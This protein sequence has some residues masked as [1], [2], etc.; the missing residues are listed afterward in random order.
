MS[1]TWKKSV[2]LVLFVSAACARD[3]ANE[4][5]DANIAGTPA[6]MAVEAPGQ[7]PPPPAGATNAAGDQ[8][9]AAGSI[10]AWSSPAAGSTVRASISEL[11]LHFSPAARLGEVTVTGPDGAMPMMVNAVGEVDHYSLPLSD[12]GPGAYTVAWR[13]SAR[14][15]D[16]RG[17]FGFEVR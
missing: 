8:Q 3:G 13:A 10:L 12:L 9:P 4:T 14:G 15:V 2:V 7:A 17:S 5:A 16:Y 6:D 1:S 11:V